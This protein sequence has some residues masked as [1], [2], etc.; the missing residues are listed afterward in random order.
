MPFV[1]GWGR[2][3]MLDLIE[4]VL[5][6]K[7]GEEGAKLLPDISA[8]DDAEKYKAVHRAIGTATT[9][10]DVLRTCAEV[11]TPPPRGRKGGNGKRGRPR[12]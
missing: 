8:M 1:T 10:D 5:R 6:F 4:D 9:L 7:F 12:S 2:Q 11:S 3:A